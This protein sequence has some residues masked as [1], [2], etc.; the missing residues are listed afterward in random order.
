MNEKDYNF[1]LKEAKKYIKIYKLKNVDYYEAVHSAILVSLDFTKEEVLKNIKNEVFNLFRERKNIS[2]DTPLFKNKDNTLLDVLDPQN[3]KV[4]SKNEQLDYKICNICKKEG[5]ISCFPKNSRNGRFY[6]RNKCKECYNSEKRK[7]YSI[8]KEN[9]QKMEQRRKY[10][11][12][13]SKKKRAE[14]DFW[15]RKQNLKSSKNNKN[16]WSL[17]LKFREKTKSRLKSWKS[18]QRENLTDYYIKE[19]LRVKG[20]SNDYINQELIEETRNRIL[21]KRKRRLLKQK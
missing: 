8:D 12:E 7:K 10:E 21:D 18:T 16:R 13:N 20:F 5:P 11:R 1:Y 3:F 17:D 9:F 4:K 15:R 2:I 14:S 6:F 19:T